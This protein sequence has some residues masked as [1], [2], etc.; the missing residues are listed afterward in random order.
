MKE[1]G[2]TPERVRNTAGLRP[3]WEPGTSGNPAGRPKG[4]RNKL[5]EEF[6]GELL[7][8]WQRRGRAAVASLPDDKLV[9]V[10]ARV[11]PKEFQVEAGETYADLLR[12]A[13]EVQ[14]QRAA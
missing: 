14:A 3:R 10:V 5:A 1:Q 12:R 8:E 7:D 2:T 9:D 6:V 13:F 11:L 4:S